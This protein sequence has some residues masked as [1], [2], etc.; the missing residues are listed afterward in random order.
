MSVVTLSKETKITLSLAISLLG[1][2]IWLSDLH[3][4]TNANSKAIESM[5]LKQKEQDG[6]IE[7]VLV[8]TTQAN[9]KLDLLLMERKSK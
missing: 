2:V 9:A 7:A 4:R 5:Q 3:A 8:N 1:G 6:K